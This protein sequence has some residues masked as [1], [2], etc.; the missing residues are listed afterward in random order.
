MDD[1]P[2]PKGVKFCADKGLNFPATDLGVA[3]LTD[4]HLADMDAAAAQAEMIGYSFVQSPNEIRLLQREL[5]ARA[6]TRAHEIGLIAK[7]ETPH[8]CVR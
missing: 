7:I 1:P 2:S 8:A 3:P 4:K 6:G 5:T